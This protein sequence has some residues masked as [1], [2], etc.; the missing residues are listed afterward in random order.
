M[1]TLPETRRS[2]LIRLTE[3]DP[4]PAWSTFLEIYEPAIFRFA[5]SRGL[6]D[7]DA[8]DV[9]QQVLIA[10]HDKIADWNLE[11][12]RGSFRGWLFRV[13]RNAAHTRSGANDK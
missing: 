7:A 13:T 3:V 8:R 10:V 2:L 11:P 6:Q 9:T 5:V 12:S 4:A 1:P